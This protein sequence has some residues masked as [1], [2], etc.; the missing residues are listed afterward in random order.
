MNEK[1]NQ[2]REKLAPIIKNIFEIDEFRDDISMENTPEWDSLAH[3]RL[4][5]AIEDAFEIELDFE[6][7]VRMTTVQAIVQT[8]REYLKEV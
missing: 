5:A 8:L 7:M 4:L 2:I 1:R 6:D 3:L